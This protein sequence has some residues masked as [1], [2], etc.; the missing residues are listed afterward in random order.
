MEFVEG[1]NKKE[2][3][4]LKEMLQKELPASVQTEGAVHSVRDMGDVIFI[5]L[6]LSLIH[7]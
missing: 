3:C 6:R 2:I 7:I 4:G 5:I 1:I